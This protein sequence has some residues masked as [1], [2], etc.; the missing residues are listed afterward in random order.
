[1]ARVAFTNHKPDVSLFLLK[2]FS[3]GLRIKP[4]SLTLA[5]GPCMMSSCLRHQTH[6]SPCPSGD[7]RT[8]VLPPAP[9][10]C[11]YCSFFLE[12]FSLLLTWLTTTHHPQVPELMSRCC[13]VSPDAQLGTLTPCFPGTTCFPLEQVLQVVIVNVAGYLLTSVSF[14]TF[15]LQGRHSIHF[16]C[17]GIPGTQRRIQH[18]VGAHLMAV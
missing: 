2:S 1:M 16:V 9:G 12:D 4:K 13:G 7:P 3:L 6:P 15:K 18:I 17:H 8:L 11:S 10:L 14:T 5:A